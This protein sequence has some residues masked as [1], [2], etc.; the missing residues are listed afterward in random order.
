MTGNAEDCLS[1]ARRFAAALDHDDFD[2][3]GALLGDNC[4]YVIRDETHRG[5]KAILDSYREAS[6]WVHD[7][8]DGVEY[9]SSV[10]PDED[11]DRRVAITFVDHLRQGDRRHTHT[12]V[13]VITCVDGLITRIEHV[14]LPG[15]RE[16]VG[17]FLDEVGIS[18][19]NDDNQ[20]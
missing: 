10:S 15:E 19:G 12:C 14:D 8:L 13:Q 17:A 16:A 4:L 20:S 3:A 11:D 5:S 6:E 7:A 9:E 1:I 18:T 2:A